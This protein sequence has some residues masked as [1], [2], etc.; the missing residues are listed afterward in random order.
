[1]PITTRQLNAF[2]AFAEQVI[3]ARGDQLSLDDLWD[4][5]RLHNPT[6]EEANADLLAVKAAICDMEN[7]DQGVPATEHIRSVREKFNLPGVE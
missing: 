1:M 4:Q 7:G 2:H 3:S 6:A 5:W